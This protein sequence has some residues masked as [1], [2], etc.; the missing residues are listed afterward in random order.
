MACA[1]NFAFANRQMMTS[2]ARDALAKFFRQ[3]AESLGLSLVY[4]VCHNIAKWETHTVEGKK[5]KLCVHRK[6]ATRAFAPGHPDVPER[7]R[8]VGQPVIVPG[9]MGRYSFVLAGTEQAMAET[10]G[11]SCHGAGRVLSRGEAKRQG[12]GREIARELEDKGIWVR[13]DSPG[14]LAEEMSDA[15]KDVASVV[16]VIAGAGIARKVARLVPLAVVKG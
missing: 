10:W 6:G 12:R 2:F 9:D 3:S 14:S 16:D 1:V 7:Y 15:Y 11:S 8:E 13:S 5:K 4:D